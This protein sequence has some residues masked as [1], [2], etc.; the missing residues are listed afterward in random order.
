MDPLAVYDYNQTSYN[1]CFDCPLSYFDYFGLTSYDINGVIQEIDDGYD[2]TI[3]LSKSEYIRLVKL[4]SNNK[5]KYLSRR[6]H[7]MNSNGYLDADGNS[8]LAAS[9]CF[10]DYPS[11]GEWAS[12][13]HSTIAPNALLTVSSETMN[14][15][16]IT[17]Y[18]TKRNRWKDK[19]G[20]YRS[21]DFNGNGS[22]GGK[23]KFAYNQSMLYK[24]MGKAIGFVGVAA[25]VSNMLTAE[26][27]F[28]IASSFADVVVSGIS[29]IPFVGT[30]ASLSWNAYG[31]YIFD[32]RIERA[33][34]K[35][36]NAYE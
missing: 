8:V 13:S 20:T 36:N 30:V 31:K 1:Y 22:T 11:Y 21:M 24:G 17:Y 28:E 16:G 34:N 19:Q 15:V 29:F 5:N 35:L 18:S 14:H 4:W 10:P 32:T 7:F 26:T 2:E 9:Y 23:L 25:S 27:G 12:V 3:T 6:T 33:I